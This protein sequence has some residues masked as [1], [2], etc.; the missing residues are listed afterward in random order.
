[1]KTRKRKTLISLLVLITVVISSSWI[2]YNLAK[3]FDIQFSKVFI[4]VTLILAAFSLVLYLTRTK[5]LNHSDEKGAARWAEDDEI[6]ENVDFEEYL[7]NRDI[8]NADGTFDYIKYDDIRK[9]AG[10]I[11]KHI[12]DLK[13][14][15]NKCII[16]TSNDHPLIRIATGDGKDRRIVNP[17]IKCISDHGEHMIINDPKGETFLQFAEYLER[18]RG[19]KV[20][21]LNYRFPDKGNRLNFLTEVINFIDENELDEAQSLAED[22]AAAIDDVGS[23]HEEQ[24]WVDGRRSV[25]ESLILSICLSPAIQR[26][27][28]LFSCYGSL[29]EMGEVFHDAKT[30]ADQS[31]MSDWFKHSLRQRIETNAFAPAKM[32]QDQ[33]KTSFFTNCM[34]SLKFCASEKMGDMMSESDFSFHELT[35]ENGQPV[36]IFVSVPYEKNNNAKIAN[37]FFDTAF[38]ILTHDSFKYPDNYLPTRV[39]FILNEI[40]NL[41]KQNEIDKKLTVG[42]GSNIRYYLFI[43]SE[44]QIKNTY[45]E[46]ILE[47]LDENCKLKMDM[48]AVG[49]RSAENLSKSL[50]KKTIIT[51]SN[52]KR[53]GGLF[54]SGDVSLSEALT[55]RELQGLDELM[56]DLKIG[57]V[58]IRKSKLR[59]YKTFFSDMSEIKFFK[60]LTKMIP[61]EYDQRFKRHYRTPDEYILDEGDLMLKKGLSRNSRDKKRKEAI[62]ERW[63]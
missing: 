16:D 35:Q 55:D 43:Q 27:K 40:A 22:I 49:H 20:I 11:I 17:L 2:S 7:L 30:G 13:G 9:G 32:A 26:C 57:D 51:T 6:E 41:P 24:I 3:G 39:H 36:A 18:E 45:G 58:I 28:T 62:L 21:H 33:T 47:I 46:N 61:E 48:V 15:Y 54:A 44:G 1:M 10:P 25:F 50:G 60:G 4:F 14:S 31:R 12:S 19:Y 34:T 38:R 37:I 63:K 5:K 52:S 59:P 23:Q 8:K 53:Q 29:R 56:Y 42:R